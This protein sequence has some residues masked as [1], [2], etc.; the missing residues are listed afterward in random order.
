MLHHL[1]HS[2]SHIPAL[3]LYIWLCQHT[4]LTLKLQC[5]Y[6]VLSDYFPAPVPNAS[7]ILTSQGA[8]CELWVHVNLC[9]EPQLTGQAIHLLQP[10]HRTKQLTDRGVFTSAWP[11][12]PK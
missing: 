5:K 9:H 10:T 8:L 3:L 1:E 7:H 11:Y 4:V 12:Q 2:L 6:S